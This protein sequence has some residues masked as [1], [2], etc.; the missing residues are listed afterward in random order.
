MYD[1]LYGVYDYKAERVEG[2]LL[3]FPSDASACRMFVD[4]VHSQGTAIAAHPGDYALCMFGTFVR[5]ES[6]R[7]VVVPSVDL[8]TDVPILTGQA[9]VDA[10]AA[11]ARAQANGQR[12]LPFVDDPFP[13]AVG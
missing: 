4:L 10:D 9:V 7:L 8:P 5:L 6:G 12:D 11:A 2:P 13:G 1:R 3:P